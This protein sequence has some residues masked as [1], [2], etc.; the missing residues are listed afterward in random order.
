MLGKGGFGEVWKAKHLTMPQK[1]PVALKFC[2]DPVAAHA[3]RNEAR[4][5]TVL[6]QVKEHGRARRIVPLLETYLQ[7]DPPCLMY[8]LMDGGDLTGLIQ[9]MHAESKLTPEIATQIVHRL[10]LTMADAHR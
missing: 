4:L 10:A 8:E 7:N 1:K 3:L 5:Y 6:D 2:L 9:E